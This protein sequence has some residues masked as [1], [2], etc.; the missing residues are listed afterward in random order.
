MVLEFQIY[1]WLQDHDKIEDSDDSD[2]EE[3]NIFHYIIHLFGRTLDNKSVY[4]KVTNFMPYFFIGL[5]L[6]WTNRLAKKKVRLMKKWLLSDSNNKVWK[7]YKS[8]LISINVVEKMKAEGFTNG[9]KFLFA[10][11]HFNNSIAMRKYR[12]LFEENR[13]Y[14]S[15]VVTKPYKFKTYEANL[16]PML[17]CFHI[18]NISG[19]SWVKVDKYNTV[20]EENK[21]S[22]CHHEII[23]NYKNLVPIEKEVNAP[24]I[25]ASFDIEVTSIDG[26]FPQARRKGDKII[27]IGTTYTYL[28]ES[29]P[30]RQ[31]IVCL[32]ET[33]NVNG[34]VVEWYDNE[35]D[36]IKGWKDEI[37]RSDCDILTGYNIFYFDEKYIYDRCVDL[38]NL[39]YEINNLSKFKEY[40]CQ[41]R[42]FKLA[43]AA[44]GENKL[45]LWNT[46]GRVH[47]DLMK[48]VQ[49][50]YK[51]S[52]YKLDYVASNF[53]RGEIKT[54]E[55]I[56]KN[57]YKLLC[58]CIDDICL[59][60][61]IH[62]EAIIGYVSDF[63]GKKYMVLKINQVE[64]TLIIRSELDL[65]AECNFE[66]AKIYWSQAKD[67]V[68]P[69]DIFEKQK[70]SPEDRAVVA[71]YCVKDCRL[72]NLLVNKL[73]VV[74]KNIEMSNVCFV[75]LS[76]LFTR[77]QGIKLFSLCLKEYRYYNYLFPVIR[78]KLTFTYR[79][80][81]YVGDVV[82][83]PYSNK[84]EEE[85][86]DM[87]KTG[88]TY[89]YLIEVEK[90]N[91]IVN[92]LTKFKTFN[93]FE[94]EIKK[95]GSYEG[96]IVFDPIPKIYYEALAVKDY[97]SL[98]P[99]SIIQKNMSHETL[100]EN[101]KYD[102]LPG[103][104]YFNASF[105][106]NDGTI[107]YRRFAKIENNLG[108]IPSILRNLLKERKAIKKLMKTEKDPFR[109]K[110]LDAKQLALKVTANSLYG[111]LGASTSPVGK[112]DIAACTTSTGKEMLILAKKYDEEI[113]PYIINGLKIA[114]HKNKLDTIEKIMSQELKNRDNKFEDKIKK[115]VTEDLKNLTFQPVIRYGDTDSIF[116]S[117]CFRETDLKMKKEDALPI[118][119]KIILFSCELIKPFIPLE[120]RYY[121]EKIHNDYYNTDELTK[122]R[123]PKGPKILPEPEHNK[124]I[125]P[126][127]DRYK[128]LL[129]EY[130][131]ENYLPWLWTLQEIFNRKFDQTDKNVLNVR[132]Y[133]MGTNI[134]RKFKFE[135]E[136]D[137]EFVDELKDDEKE[138]VLRIKNNLVH[139]IKEFISNTLQD[140]IIQPYWIR[141]KKTNSFSCN[142]HLYHGG[143]LITDKR[144][145]T[146]SIDMG[147][148]S[149]ELIKSRLPFPQDLEYEKT[150]WPYLILTK[151][152]YVGN[153]YEFNPDKFKQDCMGIVLKR[154]DNA[155]I[156]KEICGGI[157]NKLI[158]QKDP[159]GARDFTIK[160]I[161][162]MLQNKYNIKYFLT[163]KTLKMK[164][165]YKNWTRIAH[166]VLAER[167][168][169]RDPGNRPQAGDRIEYAV[170]KIEN[171]TPNTLQGE[172]I[173]TPL[174]IKQKNLDIDYL[175]YITNQIMKPSLQFLN[176]AIDNASNIFEKYILQDKKEKQMAK[177]RLEN[178]TMG[179][180][181]VLDFCK[182]KKKKK[183][184][185]REKDKDKPNTDL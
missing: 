156:V 2:S 113:L 33:S 10:V 137:Y 117:Y 173:E 90:E 5:P 51:L 66:K 56:S 15:Q 86:K 81:E 58:K 112:R 182:K 96:A 88:R 43:S 7:K 49:K 25:I 129:K 70:G 149:G 162:N 61:Y 94:I 171:K 124:T 76:Y 179:R 23:V 69:K 98:Y 18:R 134:V 123:L 116:S 32:D 130:M 127:D 55:K 100:V 170:V 104:T 118:W 72:V 180:T 19:C 74:T 152:R 183:K 77:G 64:K 41:F 35:R 50:T 122:L 14:I 146:L 174:Y 175:F 148:I 172:M 167:I 114:Y 27:Q 22:Y 166:I 29:V 92:N 21:T 24:L 115:F 65:I 53:I 17:R 39:K 132:L 139:K 157:I 142:I 131:E 91:N 181:N 9:R 164:E 106:E 75:P 89:E 128:Q 168:G 121:W 28:G 52:C 107:K 82:R 119:K 84:T 8:G 147:I 141:N 165:S 177:I 83:S 38:L 40:Q 6:S 34:I 120:S 26:Q 126:E 150:Y 138:Q 102:N 85:L 101:D 169:I 110:I 57:K 151:K 63:I 31:H 163:S 44:L 16:P 87:P 1:D 78:K 158:N 30:F 185:K 155:P 140:F 105:R 45:R 37:I 160:C 47:I 111:Q 99:S 46:P 143:E 103:I 136:Y 59:N 97:A 12:S 67:D 93:K 42:E 79:N 3:N 68:G 54:I 178:E 108:V 135:P 159:N 73:E 4:A 13:I 154:R 109:Y 36:L 145:L 11:L 20:N 144:S 80:K 133:R 95:K 60:D 62:V 176:L 71:K 153:K 161:E 184:K 125:L 48:D